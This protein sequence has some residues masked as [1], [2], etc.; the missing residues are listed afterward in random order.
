M[1]NNK[2]RC[3]VPD[4]IFTRSKRY[5]LY[6]YPHRW[7]KNYF[8]YNIIN[9]PKN[10]PSSISAIIKK[11]FNLWSQHTNLTFT[12]YK[13]KKAD[14][15]IKFIEG[16]H[17]DGYPFDGPGNTLAHAF[18]PKSGVI[19]FDDSEQW[20]IDNKGNGYDLLNAAAHEIGHALGLSHS[21]DSSALMRPSYEYVKTVKLGNDD[22][23]VS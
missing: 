21:N 2:P 11:A 5:S 4:K 17:S 14:F 18:Q 8:T 10:G 12:Q 19:H 9:S 7:E 13:S 16:D 15:Q 23:K 20:F 6:S 1:Y 22:I 3:G